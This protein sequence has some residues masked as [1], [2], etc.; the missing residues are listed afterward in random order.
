MDRPAMAG[1]TRPTTK[2]PETS[3][4]SSSGW[5][6]GK[7]PGLSAVFIQRGGIVVGLGRELFPGFGHLLQPGPVF[8]A[9]HASRQ[10]AALLSV[11]LILCNFAHAGQPMSAKL[12]R[13][14]CSRPRVKSDTR[15][16]ALLP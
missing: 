8:W 6:G 15:I 2:A 5:T 14:S 16:S 7:L 4:K 11:L 13:P 10:L 9:G 1:S 12:G 3:S